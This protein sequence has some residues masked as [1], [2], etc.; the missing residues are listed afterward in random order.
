MWRSERN[1]WRNMMVSTLSPTL[2]ASVLD[3]T[4]LALINDVSATMHPESHPEA[5]IVLRCATM[6]LT[7]F[8]L[9]GNVQQCNPIHTFHFYRQIPREDWF[10]YRSTLVLFSPTTRLDCQQVPKAVRFE[11]DSFK[12][13]KRKRC[14]V[15]NVR[16]QRI[17][18][19]CWGWNNTA[20]VYWRAFQRDLCL[21]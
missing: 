19:G 17:R 5:T 9:E 20:S 16:S 10:S 1:G 13:T 2:H 7:L 3:W 14:L 12:S 18:Q 8:T 6:F 15:R 11:A 21:G 4:N